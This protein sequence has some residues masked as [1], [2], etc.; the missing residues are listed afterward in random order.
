MQPRIARWTIAAVF[1]TAAICSAASASTDYLVS[2]DLS[3]VTFT[4]YKWTVLKE[5][6]RFRNLS[7]QIHYDP[8]RP[9]DSRVEITVQTDSLDTNNANRDHV[10]RSDDFFDV[11]QFP[12]MRFVSRGVRPRSD[13]SL[14][15][16]GDLTI[17]GVTKR[18]EV[19]VTVNGVNTVAHVG[20]LAGFET[21][22]HIDR[23]AF[24]VNGTRWSGGNLLIS[25]DV[26]VHL[27][28]AGADHPLYG[29]AGAA[30]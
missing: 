12:T 4:V 28:I 29:R 30:R 26:E 5:D 14:A 10:L 21:T 23:T 8:A 7:G 19:V 18:L 11:R 17:R 13:G 3:A 16:S 24:G 2:P 25:Q 9:Q 15:V 27:A 20:R 22:F 1:G 6:G